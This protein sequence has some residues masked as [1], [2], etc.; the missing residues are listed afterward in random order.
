M[1]RFF[2]VYFMLYQAQLKVLKAAAMLPCLYQLVA[3]VF[4]VSDIGIDSIQIGS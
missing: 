2:L 4:H 1:T 3:D